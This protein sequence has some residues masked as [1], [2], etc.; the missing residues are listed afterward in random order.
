MKIRRARHEDASS[1]A[2]IS[3]EVWMGTYIREG[4]NGFFADYALNEFTTVNFETLVSDPT[5]MIWVSENTNGIDGFLRL[6][7]DKTTDVPECPNVELST[8]YVQNRHQ[9]KGIGRTLLQRA[10]TEG[11]LWLMVNAENV[12]AVKFYQKHGF[13][14][15]GKTYFKIQDQE[16]LN[17]VLTY[18][19]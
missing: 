14:K 10:I 5:E 7:T 2:A 6:T 1:L 12:G 9:G 3:F 11:D 17:N 4:V 18:K 13:V 15:A 8:L 16:Y 19:G